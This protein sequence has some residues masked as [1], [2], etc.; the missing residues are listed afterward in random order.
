M[1]KSLLIVA[2]DYGV[3]PIIDNGIIKAV[4]NNAVD[5]IDMIVTHPHFQ[6]SYNN[7]LADNVVKEKIDRG[8]LKLGLHLTLTVGGPLYQDDAAYIED[9]SVN[10]G[11]DFKYRSAQTIATRI[12]AYSS[13]HK[14]ALKKEMYMQCAKFKEIVGRNPDHISSHEGVFQ[15]NKKLYNVYSDFV[16]DPDISSF[17][18]CPTLLCFDPYHKNAWQ[19]NPKQKFLPT[20]IFLATNGVF[21]LP[22]I[23]RKSNQYRSFHE[24]RNETPGLKSTDFFVEHFFKNGTLKDLRQI[25]KKIMNHPYQINADE[26]ISFEM[27]V[28]PVDFEENHELSEIPEGINAEIELMNLRKLEMETLTGNNIREEMRNK[29]ITRF[30]LPLNQVNV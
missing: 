14:E 28:H 8:D 5:C 9:I 12:I 18:R 3:H 6:T 15:P 19:D 21:I 27:V 30:E 22:W 13:I 17:M 7:L 26:D 1:P 11:V 4:R 20:L 16:R 25:F 10:N 29:G 24:D 23:K 2:D